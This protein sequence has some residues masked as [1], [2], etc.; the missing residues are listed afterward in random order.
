MAYDKRPTTERFSDPITVFDHELAKISNL[1]ARKTVA[2]MLRVSPA[3]FWIAPSAYSGRYHDPTEFGQG[4]Q[5]LH[6]KRVFRSLMVILDS[7]TEEMNDDE[8]DD[9]LCAALIHDVLAGSTGSSDHVSTYR[10]YFDEHLPENIKKLDWWESICEVASH[11]MGRWPPT[12]H[13]RLYPAWHLEDLGNVHPAKEWLLH[14]ADMQA[15]KN[16]GMPI[17]KECDYQ[18]RR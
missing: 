10:I 15:T 13:K 7:F 16:N 11:H 3:E 9:Q 17:L 12:A 5:I 18:I 8:M 6:T 1:K 4:G 14:L 2:A